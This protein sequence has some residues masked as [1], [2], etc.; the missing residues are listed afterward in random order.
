MKLDI[1]SVVSTSTVYWTG[2]F[3][4]VAIP[5]IIKL[6]HYDSVKSLQ[7][8]LRSDNCK[9]NLQ[10]PIYKVVTVIWQDEKDEKVP[11]A[12]FTYDFLPAI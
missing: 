8:T 6:V 4:L 5:G 9:W 3:I 2:H 7:I 12:R 10:Y 1:H 11:G